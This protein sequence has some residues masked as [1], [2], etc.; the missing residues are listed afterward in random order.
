MSVNE[1]NAEVPLNWELVNGEEVSETEFL[2]E[3]GRLP[4]EQMLPGL[5]RLL[6][7]GDADGRSAYRTLDNRVYDLFP[8][9]TADRIADRL[10]QGKPGIF[11]SQWQLLFAIKLIC[12]FGSRDAD[13]V[14][15]TDDQFLEFLLK[16]NSSYPQGIF[17][18]STIEG[19]VEGLKSTTLS[20]YSLPPRENPWMLIGRYSE[21]LGR[22]AEPA[23]RGDFINWVDI[24][25]VMADQLGVRL[26]TFK[27]VLFALH[28]STIDGSPE[29]DDGWV[30]PQLGS[31]NP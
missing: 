16:T 13:E 5:I 24:Q 25:M 23:N 2:R 19:A 31:M 7:F 28:G 9:G 26:D 27:A 12:T 3:I 17:A 22:L 11:F 1:S 6:Q 20:G 29:S 8:T 18:A 4:L 30:L 15:L 21:L 14:E 10:S